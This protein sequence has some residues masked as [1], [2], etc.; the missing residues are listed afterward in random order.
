[1]SK[2]EDV[3]RQVNVIYWLVIPCMYIYGAS[4]ARTVVRHMF[5][6]ASQSLLCPER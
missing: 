2:E 6:C 3:Q 1:M 4:V 5:H